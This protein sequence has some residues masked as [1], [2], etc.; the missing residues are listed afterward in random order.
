MNL[1]FWA[2]YQW[3]LRMLKS[4]DK[5]N[6]CAKNRDFVKVLTSTK[7]EN[8]WILTIFGGKIQIPKE[9]IINFWDEASNSQFC[10]FSENWIFRHNLRWFLTVWTKLI[11][12]KQIFTIFFYTFYCVYLL[13]NSTSIRNAKSLT[14]SLN[15][16]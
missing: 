14:Q 7:I 2:K 5:L 9:R 15:N 6:F 1:N 16:F 11:N 8:C 10:S 3:F 4:I 12:C 13:C